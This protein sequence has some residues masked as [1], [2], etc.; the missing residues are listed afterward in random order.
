MPIGCQ[1]AISPVLNLFTSIKPKTI[2]D[3]GV[4]SGTF[5][6]LFREYSDIMAERYE[7]NEWQI[8]IDGVE[9]WDKYITESHKHW[10][11][12]LYITDIMQF[13]PKI[14][15]DMIYLGD[16]IEHL[17]YEDALILI[18]RMKTWTDNIII[19]TPSWWGNPEHDPLGNPYEHHQRLWTL[20][21]FTGWEIIMTDPLVVWWHK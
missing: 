7:K 9:I 19:T 5:G 14:H 4:G 17:S 20:E 13:V 8:Q 3:V 12:N 6:L 21:D 11:N 1:V 15:Y 18:E 2:L 10:Y 16:L